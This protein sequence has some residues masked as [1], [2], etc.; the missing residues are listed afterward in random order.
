MTSRDF[1][2]DLAPV[3]DQKVDW[4]SRRE[5]ESPLFDYLFNLGEIKTVLDL[6]CGDGGQAAPVL[7]RGGSY[8]GVDKSV[9]MVEKAKQKYGAENKV[10]LFKGDM[11]SLP[12]R[13][14]GRFD[15]VL[16]LGNTLPHVLNED[17]FE[18]MIKGIFQVLRGDGYFCLQTVNARKFERKLVHF[19]PPKLANG[20]IFF[21]PFYVQRE[22][23]WD[24]YMPIFRFSDSKIVEQNALKTVLRFWSRKE[25]ESFAAKKFRPVKC[26]G[27]AGLSIYR[28]HTSENMILIFRKTLHA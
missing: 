25:I 15:L 28:P 26:F 17:H 9:E 11:L 27:D 18:R 6:G 2:S 4:V 8:V 19:L 13:W 23:L 5:R 7:Q 21:A 20:S 24:F 10:E 14:K 1:Y 3:Y 16:L 12:S 22:K